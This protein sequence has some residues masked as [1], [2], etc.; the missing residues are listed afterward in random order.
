M[1]FVVSTTDD[2]QGFKVEQYIG[3]VT[4]EVV[5]GMNMFRDWIAGIKDQL[6]GR[7]GGFEGNIKTAIKNATSI[8]VERGKK[9]GCNAIIGVNF[10]HMVLSPRGKG[11]VVSVL[12]SGTA[13]I[14][15]P[16]NG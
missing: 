11:T 6:G 7:V 10:Q 4:G 3:P 14:V 16:I 1:D 9:Y 2:L 8:M 13:V 15:K 12:V 5:V